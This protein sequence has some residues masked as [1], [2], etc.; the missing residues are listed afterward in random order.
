MMLY[1]IDRKWSWCQQKS[2]GIK[3]CCWHQ[4][5]IMPSWCSIFSK[6]PSHHHE[7][8]LKW[9]SIGM[10]GVENHIHARSTLHGLYEYRHVGDDWPRLFRK[11]ALFRSYAIRLFHIFLFWL[12][13]DI[14]S[15][16]SRPVL[17]EWNHDFWRKTAHFRSSDFISASAFLL[18]TPLWSCLDAT[19]L[20]SQLR[21][22]LHLWNNLMAQLPEIDDL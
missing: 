8:A 14:K 5:R 2:R 12:V 15:R 6:L 3:E 10:S 18:Q 4:G 7:K 16:L 11:F 19:Y 1:Q 13:Y 20:M 21:I 22:S 17:S 9:Y